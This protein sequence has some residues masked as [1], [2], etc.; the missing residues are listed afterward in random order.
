MSPRSSSRTAHTHLARAPAS[1]ARKSRSTPTSDTI[2]SGRDL[3]GDDRFFRLRRLPRPPGMVRTSRMAG[4]SCTTQLSIAPA[5]R[6]TRATPAL[7]VRQRIPFTRRK[8]SRTRTYLDQYRGRDRA[9]YRRWRR[10]PRL[11]RARPGFC[12]RT[13]DGHASPVGRPLV[14]RGMVRPDH[15]RWP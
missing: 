13:T 14:H 7:P 15:S 10:S 1:P 11:Q 2:G 9:W 8:D 3:F 12:R 4:I 5:V 6:T